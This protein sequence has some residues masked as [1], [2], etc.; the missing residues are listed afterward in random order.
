MYNKCNPAQKY[1]MYVCT[2]ICTSD[3]TKIHKTH[4]NDGKPNNATMTPGKCGLH[5]LHR[6]I[7][8]QVEYVGYQ[9]M[10]IGP[11][12]T[13]FVYVHCVTCPLNNNN[14]SDRVNATCERYTYPFIRKAS[15]TS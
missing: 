4:T 15:H 2:H 9:D 10:C 3:S 11:C 5:L 8:N 13:A 14:N 1:F 12:V 6:S 7:E